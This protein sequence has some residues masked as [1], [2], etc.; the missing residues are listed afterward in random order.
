MER[1]RETLMWE[2]NIYWL[3][4]C[5]HRPHWGPGSQPRH[6]PRPWPGIELGAFQFAG[7]R[8][9][10]WTTPVRAKYFFLYH[11]RTFSF[12]FFF[13]RERETGREEGGERNTGAREASRENHESA[14][15]TYTPRPGILQVPAMGHTRLKPTGIRTQ[16]LLVTGRRS[17]QLSHTSKDRATFWVFFFLFW[18]LLIGSLLTLSRIL[19]AENVFECWYFISQI[20]E[21]FIS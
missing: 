7:W 17:N 11:P 14:A 18:G 16:N 5:Q 12:A 19:K 4:A 8:P 21:C 1:G 20:F 15:F 13:F 2:R 6:V 10:H 9:T 3:T